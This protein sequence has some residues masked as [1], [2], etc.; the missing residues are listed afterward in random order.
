MSYKTVDRVSRSGLSLGLRL[1]LGMALVSLVPVTTVQAQVRSSGKK[2]N[3]GSAIQIVESIKTMNRADSL[4]PPPATDDDFFPRDAAKEGLGRLLF[5]DKILSGNMNTSCATCHHPLAGTSDGLSLPVGEG[6]LGLSTTRDTGHGPDR[7]HERVP[8]NAPHVF[9]L[10]A[11]EF[12]QLFHDGRVALDPSQPSGFATPAGNDLPLGLDSPL[13]AQAMFPITSGAE[14]AGQSGENSVGD[15]A[16][17]GQLAGPGGVWD[18]LAGRVSSIPEYVTLFQSVYPDVQVASDITIVHIANAIGSFESGVWR[19]DNSLFDQ[20]L[21]GDRMAMSPKAIKG[22]SVFYGAGGC[23]SCHSGTFQT[24]QSFH[25]IGMPQIG[26]GKGNNLP[27]YSDGLDDFGREG[28]TGDMADRFRFRTPTLRNVAITGPWGHDGAYSTLRGVVEHHLNPA[29]ALETYDT[30]QAVLPSDP[31]LD[32]IDFICANDPVRRAALASAVEIA[33]VN[34]T[35]GQID[36][37]IE[38]LYALTDRKSIDM[39]LDVPESVPSGLPL[40]E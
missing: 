29:A 4:L 5:F 13:A 8:R 39:R 15:A 2:M 10:G 26:P 18:Q 23:A 32:P 17:A 33:P 31:A 24:D 3:P 1:G 40:A 25:A 22:M 7:V 36:F 16:A 34:L 37:L 12:T 11:F 19:A 38:F 9:N 14:M 35:N 6:G 20:Y 30:A 27:G 21:R 28:V